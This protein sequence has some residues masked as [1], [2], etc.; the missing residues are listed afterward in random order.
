MYVYIYIYILIYLWSILR[1]APNVTLHPDKENWAI[2]GLRRAA[3]SYDSS[4]PW[5]GATINP[6]DLDKVRISVNDGY[7]MGIWWLMFLM[8]IR[9][10][11]KIS[12][13]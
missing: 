5:Q 3:D 8:F 9:M 6:S 7:M 12:K 4:L 1:W 13:S 11:I 2:L 10:D